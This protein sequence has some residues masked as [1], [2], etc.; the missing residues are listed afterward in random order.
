M[1]RDLVKIAKKAIESAE[2]HRADAL[3]GLDPEWDQEEIDELESS[4]P[5]KAL[6]E[7][8]PDEMRAF[9]SSHPAAGKAIET[10][11]ALSQG[12]RTIGKGSIKNRPMWVQAS[13]ILKVATCALPL[14]LKEDLKREKVQ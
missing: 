14:P 4:D 5:Q 9:L 13:C 2:K 8:I 11:R 6:V 10:H 12:A 7:T 1:R 3:V